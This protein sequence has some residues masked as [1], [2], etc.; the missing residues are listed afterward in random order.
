MRK[1]GDFMESEI[2]GLTS[3]EVR[4]RQEKGLVNFN[5]VPNT[6]FNIS[7]TATFVSSF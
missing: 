3:T 4:I 6:W 1:I 7:L 5:D 2:K